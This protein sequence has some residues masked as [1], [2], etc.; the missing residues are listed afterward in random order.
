MMA[1]IQSAIEKFQWYVGESWHFLLF[2]LAVFYILVVKE[3][4]PQRKLLAGYSLVFGLIYICPVTAKIIMD[5]CVGELV[6]WRMFWILPIP[7]IL[8]YVCTK[9]CRRFQKGIYQALTALVLV[10]AIAMTGTCVYA[11]GETPYVKAENVYKLPTVAVDVCNQIN[12]TRKE[13]EEQVGVVAPMS[14]VGYMRQYDSSIRLAF[15]RRVR[16]AIRRRIYREME[17]EH[18]NFAQI[19]K[20]AK[21]L[22]LDYLVYES[23]EEDHAR[24]LDL[25]YEQV[26]QVNTFII[27]RLAS[28]DQR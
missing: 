1:T 7:L 17:A 18:P 25:G 28:T 21:K 4:K 26:G 15:G 11:P 22:K 3:E 6:Y 5:Y 10:A 20:D 12:A 14:L 2:L 27:Y 24:I 16:T 13:G 8:A 23:T 19:K 9:L